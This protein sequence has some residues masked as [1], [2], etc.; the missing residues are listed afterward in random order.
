MGVCECVWAGTRV[1][2]RAWQADRSGSGG[3]FEYLELLYRERLRCD[4]VG[5]AAAGRDTYAGTRMV[6]G[7]GGLWGPRLS[8][9]VRVR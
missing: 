8:D 9:S 4:W 7:A 6:A 5:G 1:K 3:T 2:D